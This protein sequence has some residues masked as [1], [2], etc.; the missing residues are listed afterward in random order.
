MAA[1]LP[2]ASGRSVQR[3]LE[4]CGFVLVR[5]RGSHAHFKRPG[6]SGEPLITVPMHDAIGRKTLSGILDEVAFITGIKK[7]DLIRRLRRL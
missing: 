1:R 2:P 3:L 5:Q 6:P 7:D 4:Q